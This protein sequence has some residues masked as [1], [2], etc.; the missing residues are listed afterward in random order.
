LAGKKPTTASER[1]F[2]LLEQKNLHIKDL[3]QYLGVTYDTARTWKSKQP[4]PPAKHLAAISEF[5]GTSVK[6][7]LTGVEE[8]YT[9]DIPPDGIKLLDGYYKL[10]ELRRN[11]ILFYI[12]YLVTL[13]K[14]GEV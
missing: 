10:D 7:I 3:A 9:A 8:Q 12:D 2:D 1:V 11:E 5:L 13:K 14:E 6:Y 4:I